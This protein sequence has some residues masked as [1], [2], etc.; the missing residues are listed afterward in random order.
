M[1]LW[2]PKRRAGEATEVRH[3]QA[4]AVDAE[5]LATWLCDREGSP[6]LAVGGRS[7]ATRCARTAARRIN[8]ES[9]HNRVDGQYLSSDRRE[10]TEV[11]TATRGGPGGCLLDRPVRR[12]R[13]R[14]DRVA[15]EPWLR[16]CQLP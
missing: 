13:D 9:D 6:H 2:P 1:L 7:G 11:D 16:R 8:G 10:P 14:R 15:H 4:V 5:Q 12:S 3:S